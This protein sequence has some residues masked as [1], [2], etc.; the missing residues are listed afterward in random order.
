MMRSDSMRPRRVHLADVVFALFLVVYGGASLSLI[1]F[2]FTD[3]CYLFSLER[4][5]WLTQEWVHPI[6]VPTLRVL[7]S[8]LG[9]FGYDGRML[10]PVEMMSVVVA[11]TAYALL[12]ALARRVAGPSMATVAIITVAA[13]ST[14]FWQ[15]T[16]RSTPYALTLLCQTLSLSMLVSEEPVSE[17]RYAAAGAFAG[18]AMAFHAS[19]MALAVV[20]LVCACLEPDPRRTPRATIARVAAFGGAMLAVAVVSWS[21]FIAYNGIDRQYFRDRDFHTIFLGIEQVPNSSIYTSGSVYAQLSSYAATMSYQ[22]GVLVRLGLIFLA[23]GAVRWFWTRAPLGMAERRLAIATAANFAGIAGFFLINNTHNGLNFAAMT[24]VPVAIAA[25]IRGSWIGLVILV[26]FGA[27]D[28]MRNIDRMMDYG[29]AGANDPQLAEVRFLDETFGRRDVLLTPGSPFP[30]MLYLSHLNVFEVSLGQSTHPGSEVPVLRP[31]A[32]L[33]ARVA[34]WLGNGRRVFYALGD[35]TTD[36]T[37]DVGGAEKE[38][39]IFWRDELEAAERAPALG[40]LLGALEKSGIEVKKEEIRSPRG[41]RY[42]EVHLRE[43]DSPAAPR[44]VAGPGETPADLRTL[45]ARSLTAGDNPQFPVRARFLTDVGAAVPGDPWLVCD[46]MAL[47]CE[48]DVEKHGRRT[49]CRPLDGCDMNVG[50]ESTHGGTASPQGRDH[51][52]GPRGKHLTPAIGS[53]LQQVSSDALQPVLRGGFTV[54]RV[55]VF[56]D[57]IELEIRDQARAKYG[58]TLALSSSARDTPP[59]GR[60]RNF[61]FYVVPSDGPANPAATTALLAAAARFDEAIPDTALPSN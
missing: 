25:G 39:Q 1:P 17:R 49:S 24:L 29:I 20:G 9:V 58:V 51:D 26:Y 36:F 14:G 44:P 46:W 43:S 22:V 30:E 3:L 54:T 45:L 12:Y 61:L 10:V 57:T 52:G 15:S 4:G 5:S 60:G 59:D 21:I 27:Q 32:T 7:S 42:A 38:R 33:R 41:N 16:V 6:Y 8:V 55:D 47:V 11:L 48:L 53:V 50:D 19:A 28:T 31:G 56:G 40:R 23:L 34:W 13:T 2:D 35:D 37:G 18:L